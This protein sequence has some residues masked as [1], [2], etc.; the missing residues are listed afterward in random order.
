MNLPPALEAFDAWLADREQAVPALRSQSAARF[1]WVP[2]PRR[3]TP[4]AVV[5][6]QAFPLIR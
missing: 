1:H 5:Y 6:L 3:K 2:G 4:L